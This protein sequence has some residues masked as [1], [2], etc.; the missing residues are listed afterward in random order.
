MPFSVGF[1][2]FVGYDFSAHV[3]RDKHNTNISTVVIICKVV[4]AHESAA[5]QLDILGNDLGLY[6]L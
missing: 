6:H 5:E 2:T 1:A 4:S 3:W